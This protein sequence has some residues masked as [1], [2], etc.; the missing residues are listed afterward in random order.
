M[1]RL[2]PLGGSQVGFYP[3]KSVAFSGMQLAAQAL[4]IAGLGL[5]YLPVRRNVLSK[6][7]QSFN[8]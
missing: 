8:I 6:F 3:L 7:E 4:P 2:L 5:E 1:G